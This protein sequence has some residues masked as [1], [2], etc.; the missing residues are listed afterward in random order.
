MSSQPMNLL[1]FTLPILPHP[2]VGDWAIGSVV[3]N[4]LQGLNCKKCLRWCLCFFGGIRLRR[5]MP[6]Y[7]YCWECWPTYYI[8]KT[9]SRV[10]NFKQSDTH[11]TIMCILFF[12][13]ILIHIQ[14]CVA[15]AWSFVFF[16][17][18]STWCHTI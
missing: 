18:S 1:T 2:I 9:R 13:A 11:S 15:W 5:N 3:C 12:T 14:W 4:C 8:V 16:F 10:V 7:E 17:K 6:G